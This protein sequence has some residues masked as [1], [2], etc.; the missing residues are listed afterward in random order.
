MPRLKDLAIRRHDILYLPYDVLKI[1]P[2]FNVR[3]DYG[4][5][6]E[7]AKDIA[8]NGLKRPLRVRNDGERALI[9]DGHRRHK[10]LPMAMQFGFDLAAGVPCQVVTARET[11]EL[12]VEQL[13]SNSGKPLEP[14]EE[15][16]AYRRLVDD[17]KWT[18]QQ[19]A[20][21][22]GKS[23]THVK[24]R[25][26]LTKATPELRRKLARGEI[27]VSAAQ[28][29]AK[30]PAAQQNKVAAKLEKVKVEDA[31]AESTPQPVFKVKTIREW[32]ARAESEPGEYTFW[33]GF[34]HALALVLGEIDPAEIFPKA[35]EE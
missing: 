27:S 30:K 6:E 14:I 21:Q 4:N 16:E 23:I 2:G 28:Q 26:A 12:L 9:V 10:A 25:M 35:K 15:A 24:N 34:K 19:I 20:D 29:V 31:K 32:K 3:K 5:L 22:T 11:S 33:S 18:P 17:E 8:K 7:L 1:D 13:S